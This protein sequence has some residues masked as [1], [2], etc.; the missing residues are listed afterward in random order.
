[1]PL[2]PP[3]LDYSPPDKSGIGFTSVLLY[4]GFLS[5]LLYLLYVQAGDRAPLRVPASALNPYGGIEAELKQADADPNPAQALVLLGQDNAD[6]LGAAIGVTRLYYMAQYLRY[7]HRLYV[8]HDDRIINGQDQLI[9]AGSDLPS[10]QWLL[11]HR[12]S[13]IYAIYDA[14][15]G[16]PQLVVRRLR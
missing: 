7:P 4:A 2:P 11:Q 8:G 15:I 6:P 10:V 5:G 13:E 1:M 16:P 14:G 9:Q 12:V 3:T